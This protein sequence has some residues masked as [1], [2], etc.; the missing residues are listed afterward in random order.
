MCRKRKGVI[1]RTIEEIQSALAY[2]R[3]KVVSDECD[4]DAALKDKSEFAYNVHKDNL[5]KSKHYVEMLEYVL[6]ERE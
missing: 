2:W 1:M 4:M 6:G 3:H 5:K